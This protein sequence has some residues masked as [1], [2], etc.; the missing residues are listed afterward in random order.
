MRNR[1]VFLQ[2]TSKK[3]DKIER[4]KVFQTRKR[5]HNGQTAEYY[6]D[7]DFLFIFLL[8]TTPL[9]GIN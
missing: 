2:R 7:Y 6:R 1:K 5:H 3:N 9:F 8:T 4:Q